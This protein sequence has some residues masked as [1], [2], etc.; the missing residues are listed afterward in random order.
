MSAAY[1]QCIESNCR[2]R[3]A[4][5]ARIYVCERC[6]GL[7]DLT[8]EL[9]QLEPD[10]LKKLW[11]ERRASTA[12]IDQ[13][14]VWRFRELLPQAEPSQIVTMIEGNTQIFEAPRSAAYAGLTR[15]AFKHLGL[16]PTGSFKDLGMT[17]GI[18]QARR[19][20][21]SRVA[22]AS[23]GNTSAS[24]AAYAARA[25]MRAFVFVPAGQIA[26]GKLAQALDYG[27]TVLQL[28]GNFDDAMRLA[29]ELARETDLY[30]LNSVNP[31]RLEGQKTMA[32]ELLQQRAWSVPD[33]V[34]V[35]GGNLGNS[36]AIAKG[37][38][39][40]FDL[41]LI[42]RLPKLTIVQAAGADPFYRLWKSQA[43]T[44]TPIA[45]ATTLATAIK[46]GAP[47]SWQKALRG[48]GWC[49]GE[50]EEVSEQ[51]IAEAKAIIGRDGIGCEP[52]SAVTLAGIKKLVAAGQI[53]P[54]EEIVAILTG[55]VLKDPDYTVNYH[56]GSLSYVEASGAQVQIVSHRANRLL[57]VAAQR[58]ALLEALSH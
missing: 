56:R 34:V 36:S 11:D 29:R 35:P 7:L 17:T 50:V 38:K 14:G 43:L 25:G 45:N 33:R 49:G 2:S 21:A 5:A 6:G 47:V 9:D 22:C 23:T 57:H 13:S 3:Y 46:I 8:Y 26:L 31:F 12:A 24:M 41:G 51:E 20:G 15:L 4:T 18:T 53:H 28:D 54:E 52:A 42:A 37:F 48:L 32:F 30:L 10:S 55:H 40:L 1:L 27:A 39:E 58:Q 16:N 19:L 44:L